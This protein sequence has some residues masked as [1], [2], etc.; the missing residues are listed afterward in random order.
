M[1]PK[2]RKTMRDFESA[3]EKQIR[4]A[5]E[6]GDFDDLPG[7]GKPIDGLNRPHDEL[8]WL[9][10]LLQREELSVLPG[11]LQLR[12]DVEEALQ[13]VWRAPDEATVRRLVRELNEMIVKTNQTVVSG[14]PSDISPLEID[15]VL[16]KWREQPGN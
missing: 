14:P 15:V 5:Q 7:L 2:R 1:K 13:K 16:A 3:V 10:K 6:R 12:R 9:K 4:E 11:T 8:W